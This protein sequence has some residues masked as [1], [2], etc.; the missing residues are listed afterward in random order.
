MGDTN[1]YDDFVLIPRK[2]CNNIEE[3]QKTEQKEDI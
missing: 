3:Y 1:I 2:K